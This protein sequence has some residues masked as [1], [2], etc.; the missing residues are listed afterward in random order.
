[1]RSSRFTLLSVLALQAISVSAQD[2]AEAY[3][4]SNLTIQGTA[5]SMGFGNTLGSVGGDFSS[6]SVNPAGLGIYRTSEL[7]F[8]PSL[9]MNGASSQYAGTTT[10][11]NN[12]RLNINN[13]GIVLTDAPKGKR[14]ERRSW[15]TVSFAFGMNRTADFNRNYTYQGK[16]TTSSA[17]QVFESDANLYPN[18]VTSS[19]A[20][21]L[22]GY[23]GYQAF[24][25]DP[26][27]SLPNTYISVVPFSGGINQ[28]KSMRETGGITEYVFSLGGNYK[29]K[30]MIG[31]TLALPSLNYQMESSY[32][33]E[34]A[35]DNH[36]ANPSRFSSFTYNQFLN[37]SGSGINLKLGAIFK[38]SDAFRA[39]VSFHSP[40]AYAITD[41]YRPNVVSTV[42]NATTTLSV[43]NGALY[44]SQFDYSFIS[45]W[46][47]GL[48]A[49]YIVK[50]I[51]FVT[52]DYEFVDYGSMHY[53]YPR[54]LDYPQQEQVM[55]SDLRNIYQAASNFRIGVEGLV[56]KYFMARG[57]F[58]YYG[59]AYKIAGNNNQ[60]IDISGGIG[61]RFDYFFADIALVHSMYEQKTQPYSV[62]YSKVVSGPQAVVPTATTKFNGNNLALTIG[63][64]F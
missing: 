29:E 16:N 22:P 58:G 41:V 28:I 11:D 36:A 64:K 38:F 26:Y 51:G 61:F 24:L 56:T 48:S 9:K 6:L 53:S 37:V 7:T 5:R 21:N 1:M 49:T 45:A 57:G 34:L 40:T 33:E 23:I 17:T 52:A 30:L 54:D 13:F 25:L 2:V 42:N 35:S 12:T 62:D 27:L 19:S 4:L 60:R 46:K 59:N 44:Q 32:T 50:G 20:S 15:K 39:G 31:A 43:D 55:N 14:Y 3:N 47:S 10:P 8:T 18:D 63:V